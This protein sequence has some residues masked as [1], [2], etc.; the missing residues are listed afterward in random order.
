MTKL[1]VIVFIPLS[2][3]I[4]YIILRWLAIKLD[5]FTLIQHSYLNKFI[6]TLL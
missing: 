5:N 3:F 6:K 2:V 4:Y 1:D